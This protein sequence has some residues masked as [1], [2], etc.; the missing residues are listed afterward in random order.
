MSKKYVFR[1]PLDKQHGKRAQALLKTALEHRYHI[2]WSLSS[3]LS[4]KTSLLRTYQIFWLLVNK[5]AADEKYPVLTRDYL[6]IPIQM[7]LSQ[8]QNTFSQFITVFLKS[9]WN[10]EHFEQNYDPHR[11]WNFQVTGLRK[12]SQINVEKIT[13]Q[14]TLR[15]AT[16]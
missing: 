13:L 6:T 1:R 5:L 11:F 12:R 7:Q 8:K 3:Q 15:Q 9:R 4:W 16:W 2:H 10:F 14:R